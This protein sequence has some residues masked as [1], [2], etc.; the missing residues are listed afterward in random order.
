MLFDK[1]LYKHLFIDGTTLDKS[2]M[3]RMTHSR[4]V[5]Q[6]VRWTEKLQILTSVKDRN[7]LHVDPENNRSWS[8]RTISLIVEINKQYFMLE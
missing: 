2:L 6:L 1:Y 3:S 7:R 8:H 4:S 5:H